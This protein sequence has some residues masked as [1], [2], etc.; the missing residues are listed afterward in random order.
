[1]K[2]NLDKLQMLP[3]EYKTANK[4]RP[5]MPNQKKNEAKMDMTHPRINNEINP[6]INICDNENCT[7]LILA[8]IHRK[9]ELC[10]L[11]LLNKANMNISCP[12]NCHLL[13]KDYSQTNLEKN[14]SQD[15]GKSRAIIVYLQDNIPNMDLP[16][17]T[18]LDAVKI[19]R[20]ECTA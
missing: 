10:K 12:M 3:S 13:K 2:V 17:A 8:C 7:P 4:V 15:K 20:T 19:Y 16:G 18:F 9:F 6:L 1:M 14:I 11:L 5:P